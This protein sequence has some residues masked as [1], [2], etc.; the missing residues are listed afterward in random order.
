[1]GAGIAN[2]FLG[3]A[4][5]PDDLPYVTGAIGLFGT[6]ASHQMMNECDTLLMVGSNFP[7]AE[8]LPEPGQARGVQIDIDGRMSS[9]RYPMECNLVGDA[10]ATL[11]ALLPLLDKKPDRAWRARIEQQVGDWWQRKPRRWPPASRSIRNGP[12]TNCRRAYLP[13]AS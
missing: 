9:L 12:F 6:D 1:M 7:Y 11:S 4:V 2:A 13:I 8:F 10:K 3:K 5:L